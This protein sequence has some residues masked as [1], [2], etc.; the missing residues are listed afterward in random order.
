[1]NSVQ[2]TG[3]LGKDPELQE[4][5][6]TGKNVCKFSIAVRR[7]FANR[8]GEYE[9]DWFNCVVWEKSAEF[10]CKYARK[11]SKVGVVGRLQNRSWEDDNGQKR[12]ATDVIV[13]SIEILDKLQKNGD[14]PQDDPNQGMTPVEDDNLPF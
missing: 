1:M 12:F 14:C 4:A 13:S 5:G 11:G 10:L 7:Q 8:D 2:L 9:S 6:Q 3:N